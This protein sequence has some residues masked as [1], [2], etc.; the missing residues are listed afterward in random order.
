MA[1][2][3]VTRDRE[4]AL[5]F[6]KHYPSMR[7][8][9]FAMIGDLD[10]AEDVAMDSFVKVYGSWWKVRNADAMGAYLRRTVINACRSNIRRK[11]RG[12]QAIEQFGADPSAQ[13]I[14]RLLPERDFE[15]L[16]AVRA[17][18]ERQR[19]CVA[20]FYFEDLSVAQIAQVLGC[21]HGSVKTNLSRGRLRLARLLGEGGDSERS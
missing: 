4:I 5:L 19:A 16:N 14:S 7:R 10:A 20:L 11:I 15:L 6:A 13:Q 9:A 21:S 1:P 18:P 17:L 2:S 8:L 12:R 3:S